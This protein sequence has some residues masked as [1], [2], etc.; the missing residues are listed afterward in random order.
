MTIRQELQLHHWNV[1]YGNYLVR[2]IVMH[3]EA[4]RNDNR[5][6]SIFW[7]LDN[8]FNAIK[9]PPPFQ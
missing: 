2:S 9:N 8:L 7:G 3:T 5:A 6:C 1:K 4:Y